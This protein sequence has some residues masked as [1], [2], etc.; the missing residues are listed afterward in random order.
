MLNSVNIISARPAQ[1]PHEHSAQH[2]HAALD[3]CLNL[4]LAARAAIPSVRVPPVAQSQLRN[5][6]GY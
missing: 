6:L 1:L 4:L 3:E 2:V 5:A